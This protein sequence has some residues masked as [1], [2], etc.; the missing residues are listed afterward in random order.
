VGIRVAY[1]R[2]APEVEDTRDYFKHSMVINIS[3]NLKRCK[4]LYVDHYNFNFELL[5]TRYLVYCDGIVY[6]CIPSMIG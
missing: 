1:T 6:Y 2:N 5:R 4:Y 3:I